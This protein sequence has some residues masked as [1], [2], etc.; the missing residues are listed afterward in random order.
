VEQGGSCPRHEVKKYIDRLI[1]TEA[2]LEIGHRDEREGRA[3]RKKERINKERKKGVVKE[4][5]NRKNYW[6]KIHS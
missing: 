2:R 5:I 4:K 6:V 3:K 1:S